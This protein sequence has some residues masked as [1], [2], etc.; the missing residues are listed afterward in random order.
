MYA[1]PVL[2]MLSLPARLVRTSNRRSPAKSD[3]GARTRSTTNLGP[4]TATALH[5]PSVEASTCDDTRQLLN[6]CVHLP[7]QTST[8]PA[9]TTRA[10]FNDPAT[11]KLANVGRPTAH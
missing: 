8:T 3:P 4:T 7:Y 2:R 1:G 6:M 11:H 5:M 10:A 9:T